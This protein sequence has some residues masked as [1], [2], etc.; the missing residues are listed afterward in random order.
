MFIEADDFRQIYV[1]AKNEIRK[2]IRGRRFLIYV[3]LAA[4]IFLLI[5]FLPYAFGE[6]WESTTVFLM[7]HFSFTFIFV[8]IAV[9]LFSSSTYVSEFEERTALILFTRPVKKTTIYIGKFIGCF[10][11]EAVVFIGY[12]A[13][14]AVATFPFFDDAPTMGQYLTSFGCI[15]L[16]LFAASGV[17]ALFS[18]VM[19]KAGTSAIM[20]FVTILLLISIV[21]GVIFFATSEFPWYMLDQASNAVFAAIPNVAAYMGLT[22]FDVVKAM[23]TMIAWGAA[24]VFL[25]WFVFTKK[26]M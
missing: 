2:F 15:M 11:M 6:H 25:S 13:A 19:K 20:T 21:S 1:I 26:E 17:A 7:A 16:F 4:A 10:I 9:T 8:V 12:Y 22:D 18:V 5:S 24:T 14:M 23:Y 3:L